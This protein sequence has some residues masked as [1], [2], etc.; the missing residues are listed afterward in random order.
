[1]VSDSSS[2]RMRRHL[3]RAAL[4]GALAPTLA[5]RQVMAMAR[6]IEQGLH[7]IQGDVRINGARAVAGQIPV[8]GDR[9]STG[10]DGRAVLV[11]NADAFLLH[12]TTELI[13]ERQG[14]VLDL[15]R[16]L[17]GRLLSVFEP[18][19]ATR[20]I[21]TAVATIGIRGTGIY[22]ES[23]PQRTYAC[24]C[25]GVADLIPRAAPQRQEQ[26]RTRHH[27]SPRYILAGDL[28]Q[29]IV[30]APV[31]NHTDGELFMLETLVRREP[32]FDARAY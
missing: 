11:L 14:R 13:L 1:M 8:Q 19:Q 18:G 28:D 3:L 29:P 23:E 10:V 16:L 17:S 7:R 21:E 6:R 27:D 22:L 4:A 32:P 12:A 20:R 31:I 25:Y 9:L 24:T 15:L 26:V 5:V 30:V 2:E